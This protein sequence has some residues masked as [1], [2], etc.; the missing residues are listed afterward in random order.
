MGGYP[1]A[2]HLG[3]VAGLA[4][5]L[6]SL[7]PQGLHRYFSVLRTGSV[8]QQTRLP[9][10]GPRTHW[11]PRRRRRGWLVGRSGAA[12]PRSDPQRSLHPRCP[13]ARTIGSQEAETRGPGALLAGRWEPARCLRSEH[14]G[15]QVGGAQSPRCPPSPPL[16][17]VGVASSGSPAFQFSIPHPRLLICP[18]GAASPSLLSEGGPSLVQAAAGHTWAGALCGGPVAAT[19]VQ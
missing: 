8:L 12:S 1:A 4:L 9:N 18:V 17:R 13:P 3:S 2:S 14:G 6:S 7:L 10:T 11:R 19:E 16:S 15:W 5:L